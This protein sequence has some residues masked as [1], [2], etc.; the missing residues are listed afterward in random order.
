MKVKELVKILDGEVISGED[1]LDEDVKS[2]GAGDMMSEILAFAKPGMMILSAQSSPQSVRTGI[3]T[4]ILGLVIISG[5]NI[6][7][8]TIEMAK[9]N[10]FL[11]IRTKYYMFS[12]CGRLYKAGFKGID[13]K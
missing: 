13:E 3:V 12:T 6:P 1:K 11:L 2:I 5:K 9:Q 7:Q 8:Q 4:E 10:N